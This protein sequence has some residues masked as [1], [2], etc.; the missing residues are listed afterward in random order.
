ML[1]D[2]GVEPENIMLDDFGGY[3]YACAKKI[4]S[5]LSIL[6]IFAL[7]SCDFNNIRSPIQL[8]TGLT[9]GIIKITLLPNNHKGTFVFDDSLDQHLFHDLINLN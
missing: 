2:L 7:S 4:L 8:Y 9:M 6:L 1:I 3:E 5:P